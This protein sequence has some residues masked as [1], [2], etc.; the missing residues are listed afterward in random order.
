M[1][2]RTKGINL[3]H[4]HRDRLLLSYGQK[5]K[6]RKPRTKVFSFLFL[7]GGGMGREGMV[8]LFRRKTW[9]R[10]RRLHRQENQAVF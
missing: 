3:S 1:E 8:C 5:E 6:Y 9:D 7:G 10:N 2:T 4:P